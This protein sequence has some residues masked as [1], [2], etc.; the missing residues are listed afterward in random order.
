MIRSNSFT[1]AHMECCLLK[2]TIPVLTDL[3][4]FEVLSEG[5]HEM[6]LRHPNSHW[7]LTV[8]VSG[9]DPAEPCTAH[10]ITQHVL[11]ALN[12]PAIGAWLQEI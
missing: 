11:E 12:L 9:S 10:L 8:P 7:L 1:V 4:A 3:L 2:E 5:L 6:T